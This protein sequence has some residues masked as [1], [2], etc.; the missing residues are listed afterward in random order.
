ME[1]TGVT[2]CSRMHWIKKEIRRNWRTR[3]WINTGK[4]STRCNRMLK[5][6]IKV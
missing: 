3:Y 6:G 1:L 5:A 2:R 4:L